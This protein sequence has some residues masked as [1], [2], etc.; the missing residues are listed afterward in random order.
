MEQNLSLEP[1]R[2]M[3]GLLTFYIKGEITADRN[4]INFKIPNTILGLIPLGVKTDK[5]AVNQISS[6][7]TNF[8]VKI[9]R[10][11]VGLALVI[12]AFLVISQVFL[13]GL[14][15]LALGACIGITAFEVTLAVSI[16]SGQTKVIP[17]LIFE[18]AKCEM[19]DA[20]LDQI[21]SNRLDDTNNR[22]QTDRLIEALL[23]EREGNKQ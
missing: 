13:A 23:R 1:I 15:L 18:K 22:Q 12:G 14:I 17:F 4:F 20:Y 19:A 16:T 5:A 2:Y 8:R 21:I 6:S 10:L 3:S 9:F 11:I 7:T